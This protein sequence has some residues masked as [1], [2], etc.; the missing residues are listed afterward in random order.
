MDKPKKKLKL[1]L[2]IA[3][4]FIFIGAGFTVYGIYQIYEPAAWIASGVVT[5]TTGLVLTSGKSR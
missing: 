2:D 1:P 3:D 4:F 5:I